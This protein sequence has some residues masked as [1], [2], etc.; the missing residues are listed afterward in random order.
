[1]ERAMQTP[2]WRLDGLDAD[3]AY[4]SK[5]NRRHCGLGG[6]HTTSPEKDDQIADHARKAPVVGGHRPSGPNG[7]GN[8]T[9]SND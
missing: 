9:T 1:M 2:Q 8:V 3:K 6:S 5:A 7:T 4:S